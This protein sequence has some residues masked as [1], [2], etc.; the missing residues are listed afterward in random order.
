MPIAS[1]EIGRVATE[2]AAILVIDPTYLMTDDDYDAGRTP[3]GLAPDYDAVYVQTSRDGVFPVSV[4]YDDDGR[5]R[6]IRID[7]DASS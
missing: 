6:A 5:P 3:E 7:L 1:R 4:E 2:T